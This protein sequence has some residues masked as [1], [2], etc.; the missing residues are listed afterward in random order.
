MHRYARGL[1]AL[2]AVVGISLFAASCGSGEFYDDKGL[3][4][5]EE[6]YECYSGLVYEPGTRCID[7]RCRCPVSGQILC[8]RRG[9]PPDNNDPACRNPMECEPGELGVPEQPAPPPPPEPECREPSDCLGPPDKRCGSPTCVEGVCGATIIPGPLASQRA[10]DC[11]RTV[12]SFFGTI[13]E[14]ED[15]SDVYDDGAECTFDVCSEGAPTSLMILKV[16]CPVKGEG[17]CS[18]GEC[19]QCTEHDDCMPD[20]NC[21]SHGNCVPQTCSNRMKDGTE[22]DVACGG[23]CALCPAGSACNGKADCKSGVCAAGTCKDPECDD[24]VKNNG[25]TDVDCGEDCVGKPCEDG[26]GCKVAADCA[27]GVCWAGKCQAPTCTDGVKNGGEDGVDC[28]G[29][30]SD[31]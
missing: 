20:K 1:A 22:S 12:C 23:L 29:T 3:A 15:P 6:D 9:H 24:G 10:G 4:I 18:A 14:E 13:V 2:G 28:G 7:G 16:T 31:C 8:N 5:C 19:V 26:K 11:K 30:C 25:E 27:S 17:Y 21:D